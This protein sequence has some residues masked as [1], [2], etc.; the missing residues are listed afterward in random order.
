MLAKELSN[1]A[2]T[3]QLKIDSKQKGNWTPEVKIEAGAVLIKAFR[4]GCF[5]EDGRL[6]RIVGSFHSD[7]DSKLDCGFLFQ[8]VCGSYLTNNKS[9]FDFTIKAHQFGSEKAYILA[10]KWFE[11][12]LIKYA[13]NIDIG[14]T[15]I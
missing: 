9:G 4:L 7:T 12:Y 6:K 8:T 10:V 3:Y 1:I 2:K 13:Q 5:D 11:D 15:E 14:D